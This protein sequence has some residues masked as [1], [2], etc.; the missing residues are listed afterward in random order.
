[1][2]LSFGVTS[3]DSTAASYGV[4]Q[5]YQENDS[6][7]VAEARQENGKM[8]DMKAYSAEK[9]TQVQFLVNGS[10]PTIGATATINSR[11]GLVVERSVT[12]TNTNYKTGQVTLRSADAAT[13]QA[14]T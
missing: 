12:E 14:L 1:M 5:Q 3:V 7:Q 11:L 4:F 9:Q 6:A 13:L 2:A 8:V 10:L